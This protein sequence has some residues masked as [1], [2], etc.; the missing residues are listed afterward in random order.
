MKPPI[1][2]ED[3]LAL[4]ESELIDYAEKQKDCFVMPCLHDVFDSKHSQ[5]Y[6]TTTYVKVPAM[7]WV[8]LWE[9]GKLVSVEQ[10]P[11]PELRM[12]E[13]VK[14]CQK[15]W[16]LKSKSRGEF[17][18]FICRVMKKGRIQIEILPDNQAVFITIPSLGEFKSNAG[19][20]RAFL[21]AWEHE[22][23]VRERARLDYSKTLPLL[24][25]LSAPENSDI[26]VIFNEG[27]ML[28]AA[29]KAYQESLGEIAE[30]LQEDRDPGTGE[31][32]KDPDNEQC[33]NDRNLLLEGYIGRKIIQKMSQGDDSF[34]TLLAEAARIVDPERA[35]LDRP[36]RGND[37]KS[38][39][40][41]MTASLL[42]QSFELPTKTQLYDSIV[43][44]FCKDGETYYDER[45]FRR[46]LKAVG[47]SGLPTKA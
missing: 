41:F 31:S 2:S 25:K 44:Q 46:D 26:E 38:Q 32:L 13:L 8:E 36:K 40:L 23:H 11:I 24:G 3:L 27:S 10:G 18:R 30:A 12:S 39:V 28:S 17:S 21:K 35:F 37:R 4:N 45:Q 9:K 34:F 14:R 5:F 47:L 29:R 22:T 33:R 1:T 19:K 20:L 43:V 42:K 15:G 16:S 6:G 7:E